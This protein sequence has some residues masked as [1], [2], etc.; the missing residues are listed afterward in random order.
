PLRKTQLKGSVRVSAGAFKGKACLGDF[1]VSLLLRFILSF[2][3]FPR[4]TRGAIDEAREF[5]HRIVRS[6]DRSR[7][8]FVK[9]LAKGD[10]FQ[11]RSFDQF[12]RAIAG[13]FA[14][15]DLLHPWVVRA[16]GSGKI[17]QRISQRELLDVIVN[18][19]GGK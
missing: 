19:R 4:L 18:R 16:E 15:E 5:D 7:A 14:G 6:S 13:R 3:G 12:S 9:L 17:R 11:L 1:C 10:V 2:E 8:A